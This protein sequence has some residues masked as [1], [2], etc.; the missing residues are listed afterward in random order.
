MQAYYAK[1]NASISLGAILELCSA[2]VVYTALPLLIDA[3]PPPSD[4]AASGARGRMDDY[5]F[6]AHAA[7]SLDATED[8]ALSRKLDQD[9]H[10]ALLLLSCIC[11]GILLIGILYMYV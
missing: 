9:I 4:G 3:L 11:I 6:T 1:F 2:T 10:D 8:A 7:Y 5:D